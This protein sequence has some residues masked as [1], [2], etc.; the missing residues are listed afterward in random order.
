M[1]SF[2]SAGA[3]RVGFASALSA[4]IIWGL[5]PLYWKLLRD[6][7]AAEVL[8][9]RILWTAVI[10]TVALG[11]TRQLGG[12]VRVLQSSAQMWAT[13]AASVLI[14]ANG[15]TF[16]WAVAHDRVT[17]V[18]LGYYIN[19]L[20]NMLLGYVVLRE[21]PHRLQRAAILVAALG[22]AYLT[23][24]SGLPWPSIVLA[25]CFS[26]Y[27]LVRKT[28]P[29][30]PMVGL[31][32]EMILAAP[33]AFAYLAAVPRSLGGAFIAS[34]S[35]VMV[36][37]AVSGLATAVPLWLFTVGARRLQY[38]TVGVLMFV[39]P[40]LQ[41]FTAV[42]VYGE[43]FR[44]PQAVT[45]GCIWT[46]IALYLVGGRTRAEAGDRRRSRGSGRMGIERE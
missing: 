41:L 10:A 39:A 37:L 17:E 19:P 12:L 36:L 20:L 23:V 44:A 25:A 45:F 24:R 7:P 42:V 2:V 35:P 33:F 26:L 14:S 31:A 22:V 3:T 1:S 43:P 34:G 16:I 6:V 13:V 38:T 27:G 29:V 46:A 40:S 18:S 15:L 21:R 30:A 11:G 9:H 32:A 5:L 8:A 28:A 4:F